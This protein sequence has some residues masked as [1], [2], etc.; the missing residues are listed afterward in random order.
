[1]LTISQ[2]LEGRETLDLSKNLAFEL[3]EQEM[4]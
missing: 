4:R 3:T 1:M 2:Y